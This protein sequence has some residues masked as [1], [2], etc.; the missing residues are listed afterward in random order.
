MY[1]IDCDLK[2]NRI[3][4]KLA[5]QMPLHEIVKCSNET[6]AATAKLKRGYDVITDIIDFSPAG[7][8]VTKDIE[9]VQAH[10]VA[11]GARRGVRI[12]G[13]KVIAG[14]QFKRTSSNVGYT[15]TNV[16][17]LA[18]AEIELSK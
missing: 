11:S 12:V 8:E 6:I 14:L 17:T 13:N 15:S 7:P 5:G 1:K 16:A 2:K 10:F 4:I 18:D 3:H 9:R